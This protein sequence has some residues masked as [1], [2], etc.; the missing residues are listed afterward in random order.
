M[1]VKNDPKKQW[2]NGSLGVIQ[3]LSQDSIQVS[4]GGFSCPVD[5]TTWEKIDYDYDPDEEKIVPVVVGSFRQYPIKLAWAITVHKSQGK[6]FDKV[7]I[8]VGNGAFAHGQAYVALSRCRSL[9]GIQLRTPIR[10]SD[11]ILDDRVVQFLSRATP[12]DTEGGDSNAN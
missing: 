10:S 11:I 2:V 12:G 5:Q 7:V 3:K 4:F 9:Q 1:M 8:D 6:T